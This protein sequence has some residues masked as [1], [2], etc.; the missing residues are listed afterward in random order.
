MGGSAGAETTG[1]GAA[2][3]LGSTF[4]AAFLSAFLSTLPVAGAGADTAAG[5][6]A[7]GVL[8]AT[9]VVVGGTTGIAA[10]TTATGAVG[11]DSG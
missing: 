4:L 7:D 11:A 3:T 6:G 2:T 5:T 10:L 1:A 9:S 8:A